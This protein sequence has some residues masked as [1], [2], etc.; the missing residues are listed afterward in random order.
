FVM[1]MYFMGNVYND[2]FN[3][4]PVYNPAWGDTNNQPRDDYERALDAYDHVRRL[5]PNYVQM[6]HQVGNLHM[7]RAEWAMN[8][9]RPQEA[10]AYLD[11]ALTRFRMYQAVDPVFEPNYHRIGQIYMIRG[12]AAAQAGRR[13][14]ARANFEAAARTYETFINAPQCAVDPGLLTKTYLRTS[15][16]SYHGYVR[17]DDGT[18]THKH[19]S[20]EAYTNLANAYFMLDRWADSELAYKRALAI[21]PNFTQARNNLAVL[22]QKARSQGQLKTPPPLAGTPIAAPAFDI[23]AKK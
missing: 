23:S 20:A 1:S 21:N 4:T 9:G 8:N 7:R 6:H 16:L 17:R 10:Q 13:E 18:Y 11:R 19:E 15:I 3:M 14:E 22:Y 2:R 12:Q 5:A